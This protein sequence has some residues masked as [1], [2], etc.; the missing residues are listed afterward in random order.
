MA[1]SRS[2]ALIL[3]RLRKLTAWVAISSGSSR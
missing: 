3:E 1:A 2:F